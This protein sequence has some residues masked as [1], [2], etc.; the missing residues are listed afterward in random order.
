M[1]NNDDD[2]DDDNEGDDY[3]NLSYNTYKTWNLGEGT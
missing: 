3:D 2:N 1:N